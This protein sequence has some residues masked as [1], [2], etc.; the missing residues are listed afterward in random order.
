MA[1]SKLYLALFFLI[2]LPAHFLLSDP[3]CFL[4]NPLTHHGLPS[5]HLERGP[6]LS[7]RAIFSAHIA[8]NMTIEKIKILRIGSSRHLSG[9]RDHSTL[10]T[11]RAELGEADQFYVSILYDSI[12]PETWR[13][14][15][16]VGI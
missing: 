9:I 13:P 15:C 8:E 14:G 1:G 7:L 5:I 10:R 11:W 6:S 12:V 16:G 2:S 3:F 4:S